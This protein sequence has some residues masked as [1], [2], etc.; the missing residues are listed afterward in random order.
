MF[1]PVIPVQPS[2]QSQELGEKLA[3]TVCEYRGMQS[4]MS[5][6]EVAEAYRI[7]QKEERAGGSRQALSASFALGI[8][9]F[10]A[11]WLHSY[12]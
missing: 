9:L 4:G 3:A 2:T 5:D 6:N 8:L 11:G 10:L 12:L 1:A 7:A